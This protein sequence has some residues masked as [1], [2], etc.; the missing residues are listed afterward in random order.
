MNTPS[1]CSTLRLAETRIGKISPYPTCRLSPFFPHSL[2]FS[3]QLL[4]AL[5]FLPSKAA[6][7]AGIRWRWSLEQ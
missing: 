7:L 6:T 5:F 2:S 3:L 4:R 1:F